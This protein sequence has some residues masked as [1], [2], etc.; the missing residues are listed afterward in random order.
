M[1]SSVSMDEHSTLSQSLKPT[2]TDYL[3]LAVEDV[4]DAKKSGLS[5][6]TKLLVGVLLLSSAVLALVVAMTR[7]GPSDGDESQ[8]LPRE[9]FEA[10]ADTL[11]TYGKNATK[12]EDGVI[13]HIK[14]HTEGKTSKMS[15]ISKVSKGKLYENSSKKGKA[16]QLINDTLK[17]IKSKKAGKPSRPQP[18]KGKKPYENPME[19]GNLTL[20][21]TLF[22]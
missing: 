11:R 5:A 13:D 15:K 4:S 1:S 10:F 8:I 14:N 17:E 16:A 21:G 19:A 6:T 7:L 22:G 2:D 9:R 3:T 18:K 12:P 20:N